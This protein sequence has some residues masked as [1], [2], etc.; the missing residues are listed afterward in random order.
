[1]EKRGFP[2]SS[3]SLSRSPL[4]PSSSLRFTSLRARSEPRGAPGTHGK[5]WVPVGFELLSGLPRS[6]PAMTLAP[7]GWSPWKVWV[8]TGL[9]GRL[10]GLPAR[11]GAA[12]RPQRFSGFRDPLFRGAPWAPRRPLK[13]W[14][15]TG[16]RAILELLFR[17]I[18]ELLASS[19]GGPGSVKKLGFYWISSYF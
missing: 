3:S 15:F 17:A 11:A 16:F 19:P 6:S 1:M 9:G 7:R 13:S 8:P 18:F 4:S 2:W 14:G 5:A 12:S 10:P